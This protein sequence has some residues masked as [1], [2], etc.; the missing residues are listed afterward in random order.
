[1]IWELGMGHDCLQS[2]SRACVSLSVHAFPP[3]QVPLLLWRR[4]LERSKDG[5]VP[6]PAVRTGGY[7]TL[8]LVPSSAP[9]QIRRMTP[10]AATSNT[11]MVRACSLASTNALVSMMRTPAARA[12]S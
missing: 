9:S 3:A 8:I 5:A 12:S 6:L 10:A 11:C 1:M 4:R 7:L 2:L